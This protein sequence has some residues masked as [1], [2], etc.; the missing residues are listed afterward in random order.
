MNIAHLFESDGN[1]LEAT[2]AYERLIQNYPSANESMKAAVT[3]G[4]ICL[5]PLNKPEKA[6]T[7]FRRAKEGCKIYPE[8]TEKIEEG[9][10]KAS[11]FI[12]K[13]KSM[14]FKEIDKDKNNKDI[15]P[16]ANF[17]TR[18]AEFSGNKDIDLN[19]VPFEMRLKKL[20]KN[21]IMLEG[22]NKGIFKWE[23]IKYIGV[24]DI[25]QD[26][27]EDIGDYRRI[28]DLIYNI[29]P[30]SIKLIRIREKEIEYKQLFKESLADR[31]QNFNKLITILI[32]YSKAT[33]IPRIYSKEN[34]DRVSC[35]P[36]FKDLKSYEKGI[37]SSFV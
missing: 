21:G 17:A 35:L 37:V 15:I 6:L 11:D 9:I 25:H 2:E 4:D 16:E 3:Y 22:N 31:N 34:L 1:I 8:W 23:Q 26:K 5:G 14:D 20:Y 32:N 27:M 12:N 19:I 10:K 18:K 13:N 28:I 36:K 33:I 7:L 30:T 29:D 24:G